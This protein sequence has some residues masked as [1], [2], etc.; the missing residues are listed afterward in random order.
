[1]QPEQQT[2]VDSPEQPEQPANY[3]KQQPE[4][5]PQSV[6]QP[7]PEVEPQTQPMPQLQYVA[8]PTPPI[9]QPATDP[10]KLFNILGLVFAF[11]AL[12][13]PGL[14]LSIIGLR[15]SK[16]AGFPTTLAIVGICLNILFM[17]VTVGIITAIAMV[18]Y[19]GVQERTLNSSYQ[20]NADSIIKKAEVYHMNHE[21][22]PTVEQLSSA[23]DNAALT[24]EEKTTLKDTDQPTGDEIGY[25]ICQDDTSTITGANV[26]IYSNSDK[27]IAQVGIVGNCGFTTAK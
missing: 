12:Q 21:I 4:T 16:K 17:I 14:I 22:Y 23:T 26:Y 3:P 9:Q 2:P 7:Q 25:K 10:G 13:V 1:M 24:D 19:N 27:K 18:A 11:I 5:Q 8:Q 15:K 20:L 6:V